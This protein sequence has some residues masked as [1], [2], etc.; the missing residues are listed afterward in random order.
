MSCYVQ[1]RVATARS[2]AMS[3]LSAPDQVPDSVAS[4]EHEKLELASTATP[5]RSGPKHRRKEE[6][7][8]HLRHSSPVSLPRPRP[9]LRQRVPCFWHAA[10]NSV[11]CPQWPGLLGADRG[12]PC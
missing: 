5:K 12:R 3:S 8:T 10:P 11:A 1:P 4:A 2:T 7:S 6:S 9:R